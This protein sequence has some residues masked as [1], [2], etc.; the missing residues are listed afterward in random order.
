[1]SIYEDKYE[2]SEN[3]QNFFMSEKYTKPKFNYHFVIETIQTAYGDNLLFN[4]RFYNQDCIQYEPRVFDD[5]I[6]YKNLSVIEQYNFDCFHYYKNNN[7]YCYDT[8]TE[9]H[10]VS[11]Y[12]SYKN[13]NKAGLFDYE[14]FCMNHPKSVELTL[15]VSFDL[16]IQ[17]SFPINS[18]PSICIKNWFEKYN[19]NLTQYIVG[20]IHEVE[21][22]DVSIIK[23]EN[24]LEKIEADFKENVVYHPHIVMHCLNTFYKKVFDTYVQKQIVCKNDGKE[25]KIAYGVSNGT[26]IGFNLNIFLN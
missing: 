19:C 20:L 17:T 21:N 2:N 8:M 7:L 6:T 16:D 15:C 23:F 25:Y 13:D 12:N 26:F 24:S 10:K 22:N 3:A 18:H 11:K 14:T 9:T 1:M 4:C 5:E